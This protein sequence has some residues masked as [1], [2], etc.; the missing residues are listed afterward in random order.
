MGVVALAFVALANISST[1]LSLYASGLALRHVPVLRHRPWWQIIVI[2]IVPCSLFV[3]WSQELYDFGDAFLAY[4]G[5]MYAPISGIVF[6]DFFLLRKQ[7]ICLRSIFDNAPHGAYHYWK[8]FNPLALGGVAL[9]LAAQETLKNLFGSIMILVDKPF[10]VGDWITAGNTEGV[11]EDI[12][13]RSTRIRTFP[14]TLVT[15]PNSK[16]A[17]AEINNCLLYTSPSPRDR[18]RSRMPSSA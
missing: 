9:A 16:M 10:Q 1:A 11:V 13:F 6:V 15:I 7:R 5:T 4:N 14:D 18:T 8:G 12:G 3:F 2:T 17:D